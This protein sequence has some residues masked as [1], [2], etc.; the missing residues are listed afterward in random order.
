MTPGS[1]LSW[2]LSSV[3]R[4][5]QL[6]IDT[7]GTAAKK[8]IEKVMPAQIPDIDCILP[9]SIDP[10]M[11]QWT[12]PQLHL[13][14]SKSFVRARV[15]YCQAPFSFT[16]RQSLTDDVS[17]AQQLL[18]MSAI[19]PLAS[20]THRRADG[21]IQLEGFDSAWHRFSPSRASLGT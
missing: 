1:R 2:A 18:C 11:M 7:D 8:A 12:I 15:K 16:V 5:N 4:L 13:S 9:W 10:S 14:I 6:V 3:P 20:L 19:P 21:I 17:R